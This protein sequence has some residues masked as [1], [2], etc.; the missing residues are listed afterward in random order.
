MW[1]GLC[2]PEA[3]I[4]QIWSWPGPAHRVEVGANPDVVPDWNSGVPPG[5]LVG[6]RFPLRFTLLSQLCLGGLGGAQRPGCRLDGQAASQAI[7]FLWAGKRRYN[8]K[9]RK[10]LTDRLN[11]PPTAATV[12]EKIPCCHGGEDGSGKSPATSLGALG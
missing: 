6:S 7:S 4:N 8:T 10:T 3:E 5:K 9:L 2:W 12:D 1:T 11:C